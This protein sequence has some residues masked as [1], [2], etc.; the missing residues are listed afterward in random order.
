MNICQNNDMEHGGY[1]VAASTRACGALSL[2]S[3]PSSH[4]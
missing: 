1:G 2:G 3:I 4:P